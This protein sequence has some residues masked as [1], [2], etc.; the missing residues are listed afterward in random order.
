MPKKKRLYGNTRTVPILKTP[1]EFCSWII[2]G[3]MRKFVFFHIKNRTTPAEIVRGLAGESGRRSTSHYAQVSR[4]IAELEAQGLIKCLNPEE[5]T[6][7]F[8]E[9]TKR[10][11]SILKELKKSS[12]L[13]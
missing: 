9:L 10:G 4:A 2:R 1:L 12:P 6:G 13:E 7:R 5:K 8:Y 3:G 11:F